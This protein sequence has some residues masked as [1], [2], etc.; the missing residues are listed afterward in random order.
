MSG[1]RQWPARPAGDPPD[2][3]PT[4]D[5]AASTAALAASGQ[6]IAFEDQKI[7]PNGSDRFDRAAC[8]PA[9][10]DVAN[11]THAVLGEI[12]GA[13][14]G[15]RQWTSSLMRL[16]QPLW[17][18]CGMLWAFSDSDRRRSYMYSVGVPQ[19]FQEKLADVFDENDPF[20]SNR[21]VATMLNHIQSSD[22]RSAQSSE[23]PFVSN[24]VRPQGLEHGICARA[25][26]RAP[27]GETMQLMLMMWRHARVRGFSREQM[28]L[29]RSLLPH[30]RAGFRLQESLQLA[31]NDWRAIS[32]VLDRLPI[33]VIVVKRDGKPV[34]INHWAADLVARCDG[35]FVARDGLEATAGPDSEGLLEA[36]ERAFSASALD[37][38]EAVVIRRGAGEPLHL[39]VYALSAQLPGDMGEQPVAYVFIAERD[40]PTQEHGLL[41]DYGLT[42]A[43]ARI[44]LS[45]A[46]GHRL[47]VV[48][49]QLNVSLNTAR[50][51]LQRVFSKTGTQRQVEL[52]RLI[53]TSG[54]TWLE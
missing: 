35:L 43:E 22:A 27:G 33:G 7:A 6:S 34:K 44:A 9:A 48:A 32:R 12:Y 21:A 49:Q 26:L 24:W 28:E 40:I 46:A 31:A 1:T 8:A 18:K 45:I 42:V 52:V 23:S 2:S 54:R 51:H 29:V 17:L 47:D 10:P 11:L 41:N 14:L 5:A 36:I 4:R 16:Q 15:R 53:L 19:S 30:F 25:R 39:F 3:A 37:P 50:T 13:A 20:F 38:T